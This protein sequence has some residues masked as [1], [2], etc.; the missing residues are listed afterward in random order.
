MS[1]KMN[2]SYYKKKDSACCW[3]C[4]YYTCRKGHHCSYYKKWVKNN[5]SIRR[6]TKQETQKEINNLW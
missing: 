5:K 3:Y 2:K 4:D 6:K 1:E